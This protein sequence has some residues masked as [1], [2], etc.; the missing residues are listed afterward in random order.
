M[1]SITRVSRE[2]NVIW[3]CTFLL[4]A[5]CLLA[6]QPVFASEGIGGTLPYES[7][8][9]NLRN[10]VTGPVAFTLSMVGI[11]VAGGALVMGGDLSG[12]FRTL[13]FIVLVLAFLVDAQNMMSN[14]FGRGAEIAMIDSGKTSQMAAV[15]AG[16]GSDGVA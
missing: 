4:L 15:G 13:V 12:F 6:A 16:E 2:A 3:T 9:M 8:L 7:W 14:F 5:F 11:V 1:R 10:S